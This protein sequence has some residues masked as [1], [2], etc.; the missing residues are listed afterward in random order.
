MGLFRAIHDTAVAA[1]LVKAAKAINEY[2]HSILR[3]SNQY[4]SGTRINNSDQML[5]RGYLNSIEDKANY[6]Q[7]RIQDI[8][9]YNRFKTMVPWMDG[10]MY[11]AP[12]YIL[13]TLQNVQVVRH[14]LDNMV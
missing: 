12:S 3:I 4:Q 11:D 13:A 14:N 1:D 10:H 5:I 2:H 7:N 8:A 6:M 9:P